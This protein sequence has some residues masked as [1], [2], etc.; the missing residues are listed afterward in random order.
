MIFVTSD[1]HF[2]HRNIMNYCPWSRGHLESVEDMD[3]EIV[4]KFNSVV[5]QTDH[6]YI[7]GDIGF[8]SPD[9]VVEYLKELNGTKTLILGNHDRK[10]VKSGLL[11]NKTKMNLCGVTEV[12]EYKV[13]NHKIEDTNYGVVL[14]HFRIASWDGMHHGSIHLHGHAHGSGPEHPGRCM[15][16]GVDTNNLY[17]YLLHDVVM[18]L[19]DKPTTIEGHHDGS[20]E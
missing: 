14:F 13:I 19:K 16:V 1:L 4:E 15:D 7:L 9:K 18:K 12:R 2:S 6:T 17:P 11:D 5:S 8:C 10:L 3:R 20:R